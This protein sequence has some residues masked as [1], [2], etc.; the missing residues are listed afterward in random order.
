MAGACAALLA[1]GARADAP[2]PPPLDIDGEIAWARANWPGAFDGLHF[3]A[4][5]AKL[6]AW[7]A[8]GPVLV[9]FSNE[10]SACVAATLFPPEPPRGDGAEPGEMTAKFVGRT[11]VEDGRSVRDVMYAT[12]GFY[13]SSEADSFTEAR[14]K[15]G[16]WRLASS[17]ESGFPP[18]SYG[19]LSSVDDRVA[20]WGGKA[21]VIQPYCSGPVEWL[22]CAD[23]GERPCVRCEEVSPGIGSAGSEYLRSVSDGSRPVTCHDPCPQYPESPSI[24]RLRVLLARTWLWRAQKQRL[25]SIPSIY[26]SRADCLREHPQADRSRKR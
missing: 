23:G 15:D 21:Q 1:A 26:K 6:R 14:G 5:L 22:A 3:H 2:V 16:Q 13:L 12:V 19:V 18:K 7:V 24:Q 4:P 25:A 20:R 17:L 8:R 11:R 9:Y 10:D